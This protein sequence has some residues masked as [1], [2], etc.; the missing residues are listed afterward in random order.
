MFM[1]LIIALLVIGC[2]GYTK[3]TR[4]VWQQIGCASF[5]LVAAAAVGA[6]VYSHEETAWGLQSESAWAVFGLNAIIAPVL[7]LIAGWGSYGVKR[8]IR[9]IR[10]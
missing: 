6:I 10:K 5:V 9:R 7:A 1:W 8:L 2:G 3:D 4:G